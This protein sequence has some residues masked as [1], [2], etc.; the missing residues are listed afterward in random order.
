MKEF[1]GMRVVVPL[2]DVTVVV[3]DPG[4]L[5]LGTDVGVD[6]GAPCKHCE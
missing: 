3:G 1:P 4:E 5:P 6:A 2:G